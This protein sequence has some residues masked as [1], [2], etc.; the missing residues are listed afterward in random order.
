MYG[1]TNFGNDTGN[2]HEI[3]TSKDIVSAARMAT[4]AHF[5]FQLTTY[6]VIEKF[7]EIDV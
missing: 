3:M 6:S 1:V 4:S 2:W 5:E 7:D